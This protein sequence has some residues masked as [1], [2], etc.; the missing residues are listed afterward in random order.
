MVGQGAQ[1]TTSN[2]LF[3]AVFAL[4][5]LLL[6]AQSDAKRLNEKEQELREKMDLNSCDTTFY[7][8]TSKL[9]SVSGAETKSYKDETFM[10]ALKG[11]ELVVPKKSSILGDGTLNYRI[12]EGGCDADTGQLKDYLSFGKKFRADMFEGKWVEYD[13]GLMF[14]ID[15]SYNNIVNPFDVWYATCENFDE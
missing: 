2:I 15:A 13:D 8:V 4:G 12:T 6:A 3:V 9:L 5:L 1:L 10:F 7:C 11:G 14:G